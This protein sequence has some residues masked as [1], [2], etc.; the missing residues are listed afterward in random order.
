MQAAT[1]VEAVGKL[2]NRED[3]LLVRLIRRVAVEMSEG[4]L[5]LN[6]KI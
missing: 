6:S 4:D 3:G 5:T 1:N 2:R